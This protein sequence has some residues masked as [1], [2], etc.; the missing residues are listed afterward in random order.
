[1]ALHRLHPKDLLHMTAVTWHQR[2]DSSRN[3]QEVVEVARDFLAGFDPKEVHSLPA[4]CRPPSKIF[5]EDISTYAFDLVRHECATPDTAEL[6]HRLARFF[7]HA[8]TRLSQ[9][10]A[11]GHYSG[12]SDTE[13]EQSA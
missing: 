1:M 12:S 4:Q 13:E 8:S 6:V 11:L 2:L 3:E 5:A 10:S 9:I 7:S